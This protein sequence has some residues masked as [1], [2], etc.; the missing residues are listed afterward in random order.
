MRQEDFNK[1]ISEP[2]SNPARD[3][4]Y[5]F[6]QAYQRNSNTIHIFEDGTKMTTIEAHTLKHICQHDGVTLTDIVNYW[7]RTKGTVSA[8][9]TNLEKKGYVYREKCKHDNKKIHIFPTEL[10]FKIN[11]EHRKYDLKETAEFINKW[12]EKFTADDM[13]KFIEYLQFYIDVTFS[14]KK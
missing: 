2:N 5:D 6:N 13:F 4:L 14:E 12:L 8:Q 1:L 10:G 7:G 9:I 3:I 11:E